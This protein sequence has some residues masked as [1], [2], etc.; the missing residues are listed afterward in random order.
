MRF[1]LSIISV[2]VGNV[3]DQRTSFIRNGRDVKID[4]STVTILTVDA[5]TPRHR[6]I[7]LH[8]SGRHQTEHD[9]SRIVLVQARHGDTRQR[10]HPIGQCKGNLAG[11]ALTIVRDIETVITTSVLVHRSDK[12]LRLNNEIAGSRAGV[13]IDRNLEVGTLSRSDANLELLPV[14]AGRGYRA[15]NLVRHF[16]RSTTINRGR[17]GELSVTAFRSFQHL[18][19]NAAQW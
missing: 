6:H 9:G 2:F 8:V 18:C 19:L 10:L 12:V 14:V 7:Q 11:I 17:N 1:L 15:R 16:N 5:K 4:V 3:N 13:V